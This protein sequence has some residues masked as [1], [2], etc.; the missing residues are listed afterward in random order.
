MY[1]SGSA[2]PLPDKIEEQTFLGRYSHTQTLQSCFDFMEALIINAQKVNEGYA[3]SVCVGL[4][5]IQRLWT[6][7]VK[8]PN[9]ASDQTLFLNWVNKARNIQ[10]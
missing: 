10:V 8:Q 7:L 9:F 1:K 3:M 4:D 2:A 6:L 5:N